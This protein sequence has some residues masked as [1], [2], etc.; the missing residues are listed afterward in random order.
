[1]IKL[2]N[3][4]KFYLPDK[5]IF[6]GVNLHIKRGEFAILSGATG[7]GK[8]SLIGILHGSILPSSGEAEVCGF[9]MESLDESVRAQ[10]RRRVAIV[11][12]D[13]MLLD[14]FTV[15]EN[16]LLPLKFF[17]LSRKA[18]LERLNLWSSRLGLS[19]M[20]RVKA[21]ELSGGLR[22]KIA[23]ARALITE[24]ELLLLDEPTAHL[25][26][27]EAQALMTDVYFA[28]R[29]GLTVFLATHNPLLIGRG[30]GRHFRI[31]GQGVKEEEVKE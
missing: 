23:L 3:I 9:S 4:S 20:L 25:D 15:R 18:T 10:L 28:H 1:M 11:T 17:G 8:S 22:Q 12:Q 26:P 27:K 21:R 13:D 24:P 6:K 5:V 2:K 16:V 7:S 14:D 31:V 19:E 29:N 30:Y